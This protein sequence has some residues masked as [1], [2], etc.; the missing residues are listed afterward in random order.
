[1]AKKIESVMVHVCMDIKHMFGRHILCLKRFL[2]NILTQRVYL[3]K[4]ALLRSEVYLVIHK[5]AYRLI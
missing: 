5:I 2:K 3:T 4:M 1:M